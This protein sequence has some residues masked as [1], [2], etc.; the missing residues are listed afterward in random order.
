LEEIKQSGKRAKSVKPTRVTG[1]AYQGKSI[2]NPRRVIRMVIHTP[3]IY[4]GRL[5]NEAGSI[6]QRPVLMDSTAKRNFWKS[7]NVANLRL[8]HYWSRS[9]EELSEKV[10]RRVNGSLFKGEGLD[11][12]ETLRG[13]LEKESSLNREID[14]SIQPTWFDA[15]RNRDKFLS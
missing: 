6:L 15:S 3:D 10:L 12:A 9:L 2:V 14:L 8:N 5:V 1:S 7:T 13:C 11:F 4:I